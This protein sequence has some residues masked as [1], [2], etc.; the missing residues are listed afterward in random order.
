MT[1]YGVRVPGRGLYRRDVLECLDGRS[2]LAKLVPTPRQEVTRHLGV[3][4]I[5][6]VA[7]REIPGGLPNNAA[8]SVKLPP[9]IQDV[10][11]PEGELVCDLC[12][13]STSECARNEV[14]ARANC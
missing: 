9:R 1:A 8:A 5:R 6:A 4:V 12:V 7:A 11:K 13:P 14:L 10:G 2:D 3:A